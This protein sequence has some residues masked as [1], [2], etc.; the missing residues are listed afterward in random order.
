MACLDKNTLGEH[1]INI[2]QD[3]IV[4]AHPIEPSPNG[5]KSLVTRI[6]LDSRETKTNIRR[7]AEK[8]ERWGSKTHAVFFRDIPPNKGLPP[9]GDLPPNNGPQKRK[10]T[11]SDEDTK[12]PKKSKHDRGKRDKKE[13]PKSSKRSEEPSRRRL[14]P[15]GTETRKEERA[16][17]VAQAQAE[18]DAAEREKIKIHT[19][20]LELRRA[21]L[22]RQEKE[23]RETQEQINRQCNIGQC[24]HSKPQQTKTRPREIIQTFRAINENEN[25]PNT[26]ETEP[27]MEQGNEPEDQGRVVYSEESEESIEVAPKNETDEEIKLSDSESE[28]EVLRGEEQEQEIELE[29]EPSED[30]EF[31]EQSPER[32]VFYKTSKPST[33]SRNKRRRQKRKLARDQEQKHVTERLDTRHPKMRLGTPNA[34]RQRAPTSAIEIISDTD[35]RADLRPAK[36]NYDAK[37][38]RESQESVEDLNTKGTKVPTNKKRNRRQ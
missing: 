8:A 28:V 1:G 38:R 37:R 35:T 16:R 22:A 15:Y 18:L 13:T 36:K 26:Q 3:N 34:S 5:D 12:T 32:E 7:A 29:Y 2:E 19:E 24:S 25:P 17:T 10:R 31:Q 23:D 20:R 9:N 14:V 11:S 30:E 6:T 33:A 27:P 21:K 4:G